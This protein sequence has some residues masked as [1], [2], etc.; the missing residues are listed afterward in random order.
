MY[1]TLYKN[2]TKGSWFSGIGTILVVISVVSL[3]GFNHTVIYPSLSDIN[4]SL[5]IENS[6]GSHYT[7]LVMGYV[8]F[9]V[10]IVLGYVFL[11]W[12]S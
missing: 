6:S 5:T 1:I 11:V 4:S 2:S 7:L 10:P 12:R 8:S 3:L 9:L